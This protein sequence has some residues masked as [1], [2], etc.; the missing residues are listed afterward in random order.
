MPVYDTGKPAD[1]QIHLRM[2]RRS[3]SQGLPLGHDDG[4]VVA[5]EGVLH[6]HRVGL[7][8]E[9]AHHRHDHQ[10]GQ[11]AESAGV[12]G[13]LEQSWKAGAHEDV[14]QHHHSGEEK[15]GPAGG[16][17]GLLPVQAVEEGGQEG[18]RQ[19]APGHAHELGDEGD[20]GPVLDD[21]QHH[22]DGD[23]NHDQAPDD[24]DLA[25][26]I[27]IFDEVVLQEVQGEGGTGGQ[28]QGGQGGHG[29]GEH[30]D[31][32]HGDEH[33]GQSGEHGGDDGVI[34]VGRHVDLVG[35]EPPEAAQE[36]A[37]AGHQQGEY[38]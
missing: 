28:H 4:L 29:G 25:L 26:L 10:S 27:H 7:A 19:R 15:A 2:A 31:D 34:S 23:E 24:A 9:E 21:G 14:G 16:G 20:A 35:E 6:Q 1:C 36:V 18:A 3:V 32:H 5:G 33:I 13:R 11:H 22:G 38:A 8:G 12:D 17:G 30:Q 37:A